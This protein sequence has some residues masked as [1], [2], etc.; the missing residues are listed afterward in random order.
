MS[1]MAIFCK[2]IAPLVGN[3]FPVRAA[4]RGEVPAEHPAEGAIVYADEPG[5]RFIQD[6]A[7]VGL[8]K[9]AVKGIAAAVF[10]QKVPE[11]SVSFSVFHGS[12]NSF[13]LQK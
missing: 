2:Q 6:I 10:F 13:T 4:F 9:I 8:L 5:Q 12:L 7:G 11:E 1:V 3:F